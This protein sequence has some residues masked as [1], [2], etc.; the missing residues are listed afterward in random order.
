MIAPLLNHLWQSTIFAGGIGLLALLFRNNSANVRFGMWF[1]ASLKFLIPFSLF[2]ILG[3]ALAPRHLQ[4]PWNVGAT[5]FIAQAKPAAAPF[6]GVAVQLADAPAA[7]ISLDDIL[8]G[9]WLAGIIAVSALWIAK[10]IRLKAAARAAMPLSIPAPFPVCKSDA[11]MEPGLVGLWR[12][13]LL[14]PAGIESR[15]TPAEMRAILAHEMCHARRQDN[16]TAAL[17]M[18]VQAIFWFHPLTW[19]IGHRL[20]A[21]REQACD[22]AVIASG[23][24][25]G[26][27]AES[28]LKV[29]KFYLHSPLDCASG[30]SGADLKVRVEAIMENRLKKKLGGAKTAAIA[31]IATIAIGIPVAAGMIPPPD[32]FVPIRPAASPGTAAAL[33]HLIEAWEKRQLDAGRLTPVMAR[34]CLDAWIQTQQ[35][36]EGWGGL[37]SITFQGVSPTGWDLYS[38]R[39]ANQLTSWR[40]APLASDGK[41]GGLDWSIAYAR[42]DRALPSSGTEGA[43]RHQIEAWQRHRPAIDAM[44]PLLAADTRDQQASI[45]NLFDGWGKLKSLTFGHVDG[46]GWDVYDLAFENGRGTGSIGPLTPDGK[47]GSMEFARRFSHPGSGSSPGTQAS[48]R[49][50]IESLERGVPDYAEMTP[51][52]AAV[53]RAQ[54]QGTMAQIKVWGQLKSVTFKFV[55]SNGVDL[56]DVAFEHGGAQWDVAPLTTDGK[57]SSEGFSVR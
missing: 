23:N 55:T 46:N 57:I 1:A 6:T 12:P 35:E 21:E 16:L 17:H 34:L 48:L 9:V 19:W 28:I 43:L 25:P 10:H 18:L 33:R 36:F 30:I 49:R 29:C 51:Q 8:L 54:S 44:T 2:A 37:K 4:Q 11:L 26:V 41:I 27:Y 38:V 40:I 7:A 22:E 39:F 13:V 32:A 15:L 31:A 3:A 45:Q 52:L 5:S 24:D 56:F 47:V 42:S 20:V 14:L 50:F 53:V